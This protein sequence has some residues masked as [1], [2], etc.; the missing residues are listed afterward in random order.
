MAGSVAR[1]MVE[2]AT[3][4][5]QGL[6]ADQAAQATFDFEDPYRIDWA[7]YPREMAGDE[8]QGLPMEDLSHPERTLVYRLL[9]TGVSHHTFAKIASIMSLEQVLNKIEGYGKNVDLRN[10]GRYWVAI[11]GEPSLDGTWAWRYEGHHVSIHHTIVAGEVVAS[12]PLFLGSN[13]ARVMHHG[14][15]IIRPLA[16]EEEAGR[17]LVTMLDPDRFSAALLSEVAPL[18]MV[19]PNVSYVPDVSDLGDPRH[20]L[21]GFQ[22]AFEQMDDEYK[23]SVRFDRERPLGLRRADMD[24]AEQAVLDDLIDIYVSRLPEPL[25]ETETARLDDA[26][27][28]DVHFAW[29]GPT[30]PGALHYYRLHGPSFLVE[31]DCVQDDGNHIHAIWRDPVRDFG[32]D[33]LRA[34]VAARH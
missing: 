28:S 24:S 34:H 8:A 26:G 25:R 23:R 20:A 5:L 4:L 7:Y 13:P 29:A 18:D 9:E 17:E 10:A 32:R 21:A 14:H 19:V 2:R 27:R 11:F 15:A 6:P 22:N 33:V 12:T 30:E 16:E 1:L 31:Y 3:A